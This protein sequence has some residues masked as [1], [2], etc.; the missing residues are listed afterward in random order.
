MKCILCKQE[1]IQELSFKQLLFSFQKARQS[2]LCNFCKRKFVQLTGPRCQYC[3]KES[4]A[5]VCKDCLF[6]Q[7]VYHD[8]I[9]INHPYYRYNHAF[10]DLMVNYKRYGDYKI[11]KVLQ[12]LIYEPI[13]EFDFDYF[14]PIP[15]SKEHRKIRR[16]DTI[17]GIF[18][19]LV[20]LTPI[21]LKMD[22]MG[23]QG[24]RNKEERLMARQSFFVDKSKLIQDNIRQGSFLLLD[25]IYTTGRTLYHARDSLQAALP[26]ARIESFS[27]CH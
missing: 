3:G 8:Q 1:F 26:N 24:E 20:P 17:Q 4:S 25:D 19:D 18:A 16:F 23:A 22:K 21:L 10:H 15:T 27:I 7:E 11:R 9:L 12:E 6:W 5:T 13:A 14:V 2:N